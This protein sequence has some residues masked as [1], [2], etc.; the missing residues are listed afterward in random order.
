MP[1]ALVVLSP[2]LAVVAVSNE[3]TFLLVIMQNISAFLCFSVL[4]FYAIAYSIDGLINHFREA[5]NR[6]PAKILLPIQIQIEKYRLK[7]RY[8]SICPGPHLDKCV[9][10]LTNSVAVWFW[11]FWCYLGIFCFTIFMNGILWQ[12][13]QSQ[14]T[15]KI[16]VLKSIWSVDCMR[17]V[18]ST[19]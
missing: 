10:L 5:K 8:H 1:S 16:S 17:V 12:I 9:A 13:A 6:S 4:F 11:V 2:T 3:L 7:Y 14:N 15:L 18:N 19:L